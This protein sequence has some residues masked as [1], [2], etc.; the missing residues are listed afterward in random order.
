MVEEFGIPT[1]VK[2]S[3]P[4]FRPAT[5]LF[6]GRSTLWGCFLLSPR[7]RPKS[8]AVPST[9]IYEMTSTMFRLIQLVTVAAALSLSA[10]AIAAEPVRL[11]ISEV[12]PVRFEKRGDVLFADFGKDVY[13]NLRIEF[14]SGPP[15]GTVK[16]RL[17]EKLAENGTIDRNPPGSVNYREIPLSI[18]PGRRRYQLEIPPKKFHLGTA[19]VKMPGYIGEVTP[20]RYAEIEGAALPL[21]A[22][23][24]HQLFVHA[25][26]DDK[27]SRFE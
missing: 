2:R 27:A 19:S 17:G 11:Q 16:V 18:Q 1:A 21:P 10:A 13:G 26:F 23:G 9:I 25:P 14:S 8:L 5:S 22:S 24:L 7:C 20:F 15:T 12:A 6:V 3:R 4:I